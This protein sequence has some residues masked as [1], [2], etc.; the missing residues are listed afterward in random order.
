MGKP[1]GGEKEG[2]ET[3]GGE[4]EGEESRGN[5]VKGYFYLIKRPVSVDDI[6][7][8]VYPRL[9]LRPHTVL[10]HSLIKSPTIK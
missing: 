2:G 9:I 7:D 8:K 5:G 1:E 3:D 6:D 4:P 10:I